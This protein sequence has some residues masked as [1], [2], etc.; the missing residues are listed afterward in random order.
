MHVIGVPDLP[1]VAIT[2]ADVVTASLADAVVHEACG[3]VPSTG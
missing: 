2:S 3:L 1:G